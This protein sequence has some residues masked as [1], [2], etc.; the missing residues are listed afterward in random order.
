MFL[1]RQALADSYNRDLPDGVWVD[2]LIGE[3]E[4]LLIALLPHLGAPDHGGVSPALVGDVIK[5]AVL[6]V[7]RNPEGFQSEQV[8]S[9]SYQRFSAGA[10]GDVWFPEGDL[11]LLAAP[12]AGGEAF[13]IRLG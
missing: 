1:D 9:A 11:A 7:V 8:E 13:E 12:D 6:R 3:A 4:R 2:S 10:S 5:R